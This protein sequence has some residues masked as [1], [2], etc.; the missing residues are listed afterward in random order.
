M[1]LVVRGGEG[2][3]ME[4][5][6]LLWVSRLNYSWTPSCQGFF[7]PTTVPSHTPPTQLSYF[8]H[9]QRLTRHPANQSALA[10]AKQ[11]K[12][13]QDRTNMFALEL[14]ADLTG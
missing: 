8:R 13:K 7:Y 14:T 12:T 6:K 11:N 9:S 4:Q 1:R 5:G 10:S 2:E 3:G